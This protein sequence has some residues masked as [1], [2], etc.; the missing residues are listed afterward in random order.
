MSSRKQRIRFGRPRFA[1]AFCLSLMAGLP[2]GARFKDGEGEGDGEGAGG[3]GGE[4]TI[5]DQIK[6]AVDAATAPLKVNRDKILGEK[7]EIKERLDKLSETIT[8]LGGDE[9][10]LRLVALHENL[11]KDEL[12]KLLADG[13]HDEWFEKKTAA[14]RTGHQKELETL[15]AQVQELTKQ[16]DDAITRFTTGTL[17]N[18]VRAGCSAAGVVDTAIG[19]VVLRT[20]QVFAWDEELG[21]HV[22][23]DESGEIVYGKDG[24]T[25]MT[26]QEWIEGRKEDSRHWFP[27]SKGAG[28][29]GFAG[30][31]KPESFK[32][33]S[34]AEYDKHR[35][36]LGIKKYGAD[37]L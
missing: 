31:L 16:K 15:K 26:P 20:M 13:R 21:R 27:A 24:K 4:P 18:M 33:M 10:I 14:L 1:G 36:K 19:D 2:V 5:A 35:E 3:G 34:M 22:Q 37:S 25:P 32:G 6:A 7:R 23:K 30:K 9:G 11:S 8:K 17:E 12:G 28:A 29:E